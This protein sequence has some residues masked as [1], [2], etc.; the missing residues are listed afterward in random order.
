MKRWQKVLLVV[1]VFIAMTGTVVYA[2][3]EQKQ[4][5]Q[6]KVTDPI[7][8]LSLM[9]RFIAKVTGV[10][11]RSRAELEEL[12]LIRKDY[13]DTESAS[14]GEVR[15]DIKRV[16]PHDISLGLYSTKTDIEKLETLTVNEYGKYRS[17]KKLEINGKEFSISYGF[18]ENGEIDT[19]FYIWINPDPTASD[20]EAKILR[21]Y[22]RG[23]LEE[24]YGDSTADSW[25]IDLSDETKYQLSLDLSEVDGEPLGTEFILH[26]K[27]D[28]ELPD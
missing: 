21:N 7:E 13:N 28:G 24:L 17:D 2:A 10:E 5:M 19:V 22:T 1:A 23:Y 14:K 15:E 9:E 12:G 4:L 11:V 27:Q 16:L 3:H 6:R 18:S 20:E 26:R 25:F 8:E